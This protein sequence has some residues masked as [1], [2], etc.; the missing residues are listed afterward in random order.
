MSESRKNPTHDRP[1]R[2]CAVCCK[3]RRHVPSDSLVVSL[4][5]R[6]CRFHEW[7]TDI[8]D[9]LVRVLRAF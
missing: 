1:N 9:R 2:F 4:V 3:P 8:L 6:R 7:R 5:C